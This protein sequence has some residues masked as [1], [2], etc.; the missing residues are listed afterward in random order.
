MSAQL[1]ERFYTAFANKDADAMA[2]CY[3]PDA[4][5]SDPVFRDLRGTQVTAM[6]KML[7][8]R[9]ADL[10]VTH[11]DVVSD[12]AV[13]SAHW[14]A[15]YTFSQTGR[16][17]HNAID[18]RFTFA[19]GLIATHVDQFDLWRWTRMALGLPGVLLGWSPLVQNKVRAEASKGL[20]LYV[21]RHRLG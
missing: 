19:N 14:D 16:K 6:W 7:C 15:R 21:K 3:A 12:G 10:V 9:G 4:T 1:I 17:V 20:T 11:R 5:F 2:Q 18:A 13:G 8:A